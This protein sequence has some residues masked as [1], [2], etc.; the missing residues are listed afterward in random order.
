VIEI[1]RLVP[2]MKE[3]TSIREESDCY[4]I[5]IA[6]VDK[7]TV[8]TAHKYKN[9]SIKLEYGKF[10]EQLQKVIPHLKNA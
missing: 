1:D 9:K 4:V 6:S 10:S 8:E 2:L 3:N 7:K 5:E